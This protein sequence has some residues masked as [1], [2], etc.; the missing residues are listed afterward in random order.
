M[1]F[2]NIVNSL[3]DRVLKSEFNKSVLVLAGGTAVAQAVPI[4]ISPILIRLYTPEDFGAF[5]I[6]MSIT[7]IISVIACG[8]YELAIMLPEK[9]EDA[10]N[11]AAVAFLFNVFVSGLFFLF[12]LFFGDWLLDVLNA[13]NLGWL[14]YLAPLSVFLLGTFSILNY[15]NNRFK[16]YKDISKANI[17]KSLAGAVVQIGMGFLKYKTTGLVFGYIASQLFSNF[18]LFKNISKYFSSINYLYIKTMFHKYKNFPIYYVPGALIDTISSNIHFFFISFYF[19]IKV[20]GLYFFAYKIVSAPFSLIASAISQVFF[21]EFSFLFQKDLVSARNFLKKTALN[22]LILSISVNFA[23]IVL[24]YVFWSFIFGLKWEDSKSIAIILLISY[25]IRFIVSPI[26]V[27]LVSSNKLNYLLQWQI[28]HFAV[29]VIFFA[30][31]YI[32]HISFQDFLL[33]LI[34]VEWFIYSVY[35]I[36]IFKSVEI[37]KR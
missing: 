31:I 32:F 22:L 35:L 37:K 25:L 6:F 33:Y 24:I 3:K 30:V 26:S 28:L 1:G 13:K 11:V 16:L 8:K 23:L 17:Y 5:A 2:M 21:R 10:I 7:S 4:L 29:E 36:F 15:T 27:A 34:F 12:I 18:K 19:G 14:I 20:T 9:D